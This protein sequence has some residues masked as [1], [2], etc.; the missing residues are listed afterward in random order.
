MTSVD[1]IPSTALA[2]TLLD[3][4][5][6]L[7]ARRLEK[8]IARAE[9][10]RILDLARLGEV[11]VRYPA[12]RGTALLRGALA[13]YAPPP[14]TRSGL[15]ERFLR[16]VR[17]AGLPGPATGFNVIGYELD[18][19]WPELR[20]AVE[21]G[22]FETHGSRLAFEEDPV[23]QEDLKLA[24]VETI[25][26]TGL[27]LAREPDSVMERI[28]TLLARRRSELDADRRARTTAG[29]AR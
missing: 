5:A 9:E 27:R 10:L 4:A 21:L 22:V 28:A 24:G 18:A 29:A 16:L 3:L 2:R 11:L 6:T 19:Y 15:E 14:F 25:R 1:G 12:H 17:E 26:V 8:A 20:F 7:P 13:I 23:R